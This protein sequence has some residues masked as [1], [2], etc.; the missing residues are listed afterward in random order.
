MNRTS[1]Y[2]WLLGRTRMGTKR[3]SPVGGLAL[4]AVILFLTLTI[5]QALAGSYVPA[6]VLRYSGMVKPQRNVIDYIGAVVQDQYS[7]VWTGN[8]QGGGEG[9]GR[10]TGAD[11]TEGDCQVTPVRAVA[12]GTI[13]AVVSNWLTDQY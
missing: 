5:R 10:H 7:T 9:S 12:Q 11:I 13:V 8:Y 4:L 6:T 2:I 3:S 1:F